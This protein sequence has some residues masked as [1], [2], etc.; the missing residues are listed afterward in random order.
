M[1]AYVPLPVTTPDWSVVPTVSDADGIEVLTRT[2]AE[3]PDGLVFANLVDSDMQY[4]HRND[5]AGYAANLEHID[6]G[7]TEAM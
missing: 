6:A 5:V 4:G 7:L 2:L 3:L 1:W